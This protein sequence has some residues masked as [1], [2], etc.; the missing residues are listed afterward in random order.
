ML[1]DCRIADDPYAIPKFDISVDDFEDIVLELKG[2]HEQFSDC[3]A[4][5]EPRENFYNY[6]VGRLSPL[7][8]KSIEPI[9]LN[10]ENAKVRAMQFFV[11][12]AI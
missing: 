1:P 10:I 6:L 8:R 2:F 11:S 5:T 7:E 3:F 4:R 9:A 12:D